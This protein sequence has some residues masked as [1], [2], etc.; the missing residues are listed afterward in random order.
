MVRSVHEVTQSHS[1]GS[2]IRRAR[3][4]CTSVQGIEEWR[5]RARR[6]EHKA[7]R[8]RR[9]RRRRAAGEGGEIEILAR[10]ACWPMAGGP[11]G[12]TG[13]HAAFGPVLP[14]VPGLPRWLASSACRSSGPLAADWHVA[15]PNRKCP[16]LPARLDWMA[17]ERVVVWYYGRVLTGSFT[18]GTS[19]SHGHQW[20]A[21]PQSRW[22]ETVTDMGR[23]RGQIRF[24]YA[25]APCI[26]PNQSFPSLV[27]W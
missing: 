2:G 17:K 24:R 14:S 27:A 19:P 18:T 21:A 12:L 1:L 7:K 20:S 3:A 15:W 26:Q 16:C 5:T 9:G 8:M 23:S 11:G 4:R 6:R 22:P 13:S 25:A 10:Q